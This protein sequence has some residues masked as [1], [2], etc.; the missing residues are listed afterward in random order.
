MPRVR[1]VPQPS[2]GEARRDGRAG[3]ETPPAPGVRA[4]L[5]HAFRRG[6]SRRD[7][8][9]G[10]VHLARLRQAV[11]QRRAHP[12]AGGTAVQGAEECGADR[13]AASAALEGALPGGVC[14]FG[15]PD[16]QV[17]HHELPYAL[18]DE[19]KPHHSGSVLHA[20]VH[21]CAPRHHAGDA[22]PGGLLPVLLR[23]PGRNRRVPGLRP[24]RE[25]TDCRP[26]RGRPD[27]RGPRRRR[28]RR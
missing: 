11:E 12:T 7:V 28:G 15:Q 27:V 22:V 24:G 23:E 16:G 6:R 19:V 17:H 1:A 14:H 8:H 21:L 20:R 18:L 26:V 13:R 2:D 9:Q 3:Q 5:P 4:R 25:G 10:E